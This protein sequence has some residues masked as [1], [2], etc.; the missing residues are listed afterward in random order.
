[1]PSYIALTYESGAEL[2]P[3]LRKEIAGHGWE[4]ADTS[5]Y[6]ELFIADVARSIR[7]MS[8]RDI[9]LMTLLC[10]TIPELFETVSDTRQ[11]W[12]SDARQID[13]HCVFEIS[14]RAGGCAILDTVSLSTRAGS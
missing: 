14:G 5:A 13:Y 8:P 12:L 4:V 2:P 7:P 9:T 6:P 11:A 1:M 10:G 3:A